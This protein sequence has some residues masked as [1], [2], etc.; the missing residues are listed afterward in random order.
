MSRWTGT[1]VINHLHGSDFGSFYRDYPAVLKPVL[2]KA[3]NTVETSIILTPG[4]EEQFSEFP[5][6]KIE[7]VPNFYPTDFDKKM[8][9]PRDGIT[10]LY[11]SHLMYSKGIFDFLE[12]IKL[13]SSNYP[14]IFFKIAGDYTS[15]PTMTAN[16]V[17]KEIE[18][19]LRE[20]SDLNIK[21][22]GSILTE[23][24][25]ELLNESDILVLPT[26]YKSEAVPLVILEAM[27]CGNAIVTTD[28][29]YLSEIID[30]RNG[31]L[32]ESRNPHQLAYSIM[33]LLSDHDRLLEIQNHNIKEAIDKYKQEK[34]VRRVNDVITG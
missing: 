26:F 24:R 13:I 4:M 9:K 16:Q 17:R 2:K 32:V 34:F 7:I 30:E 5:E 11:F 12:A 29:N 10:I 3:Y 22:R 18:N 15:D 27:R 8:V 21:F 1:R 6:M 28:H 14:E 31:C 25:F 23:K 20:H 33:N 19:F